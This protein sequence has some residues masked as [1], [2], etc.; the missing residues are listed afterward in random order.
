MNEFGEVDKYKAWLVVNWLFRRFF[1]LAHIDTIRMMW[2]L[3]HANMGHLLVGCQICFPSW[4]IKLGHVHWTT[5][6]ICRKRGRT[7]D[8]QLH[9]ALY[10]LNQVPRVWFSHIESHFMKEGFKKCSNEQNFFI[11]RNVKGNILIISIYVDNL[12]YNGDD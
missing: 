9:K 5:R 4:R 10:D 6:R 2:H 3:Q 8:I 7:P 11:K 1:P 12:I